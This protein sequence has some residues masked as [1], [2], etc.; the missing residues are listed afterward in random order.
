MDSNYRVKV[1]HRVCTA[2]QFLSM[3]LQARNSTKLARGKDVLDLRMLTEL[4]GVRQV[5]NRGVVYDVVLKASVSGAFVP[6][7]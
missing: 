2:L 1:P 4:Y 6:I 5:S 7:C 3:G